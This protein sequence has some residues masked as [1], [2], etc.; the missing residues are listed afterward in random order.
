MYSSYVRNVL[1]Y[2]SKNAHWTNRMCNVH[3]MRIGVGVSAVGEPIRQI[4]SSRIGGRA[5]HHAPSG[6]TR[7]SSSLKLIG[8]GDCN[9]PP[10]CSRGCR[11]LVSKCTPPPQRLSFALRCVCR[12]ANETRDPVADPMSCPS[13]LF[14]IRTVGGF[15]TS[16]AVSL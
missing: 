2:V 12:A 10:V 15:T 8:H 13:S 7:P 4:T 11:G 16:M 14:E 9:Q 3:N 5:C 1:A 6:C